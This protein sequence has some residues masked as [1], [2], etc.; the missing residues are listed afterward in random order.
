MK[1]S[2]YYENKS[3]RF[4]TFLEFNPED[5]GIKYRD[6]KFNGDQANMSFFRLNIAK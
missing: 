6:D 5:V 1:Y 3:F 4:F 2:N